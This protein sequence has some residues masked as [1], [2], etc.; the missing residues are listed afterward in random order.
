MI[1]SSTIGKAESLPVMYLELQ[2]EVKLSED[3]QITTFPPGGPRCHNGDSHIGCGVSGVKRG[4]VADE[5]R[6]CVKKKDFQNAAAIALIN[7]S[8]IR[9]QNCR[10]E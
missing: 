10:H 3:E 9:K 1:N 4:R 7:S 6:D 2:R 8:T 5:S